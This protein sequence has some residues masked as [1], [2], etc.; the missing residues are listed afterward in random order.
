MKDL[1]ENSRWMKDLAGSFI[2]SF[3]LGNKTWYHGVISDGKFI[4]FR[5]NRSAQ[6][7]WNV[8]YRRRS[9]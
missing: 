6:W 4:L 5:L 2:G 1:L 8:A 7:A 9:D 3:Y